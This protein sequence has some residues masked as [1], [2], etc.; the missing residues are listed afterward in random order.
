MIM[1]AVMGDYDYS[2]S[3][4]SCVFCHKRGSGKST[5]SH[6]VKFLRN[7]THLVHLP[8][9]TFSVGGVDEDFA[10][11]FATRAE[12]LS[13]LKGEPGILL[14]HNPLMFD[15][16]E[17]DQDVIML[18]GDTHGGQFPLPAWLWNLLGYEKNAK[19]NQGWFKDGKKQMFVTRGIGTSHWPIRIL[20]RPEI[21]VI[22]F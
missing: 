6:K 21:V 22:H 14:C 4:Q 5:Q 7:T 3:R 13:G 20:R 12:I 18:A 10:D 17:A 19:Y 1:W 15:Y 8:Q 2:N 11:S 9:G 16:L